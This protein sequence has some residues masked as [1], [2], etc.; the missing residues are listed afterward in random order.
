MTPSEEIIARYSQVERIRDGLGRTLGVRRLKPTMQARAIDFAASRPDGLMASLYLAASSV[1]E[2]DG[3][4]VPPAKSAAELESIVDMLDEE[5]LAAIQV[6]M[7]RFSSKTPEEVV[8]T[9]KK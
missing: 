6:A 4:P 7:S 5:G 2:I 1:C 3:D 8:A 9:A